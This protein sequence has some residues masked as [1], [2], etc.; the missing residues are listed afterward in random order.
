MPWTGFLLDESVI[1]SERFKAN[2][3]EPQQVFHQVN[4]AGR[5]VFLNIFLSDIIGSK[6][7]LN[8]LRIFTEIPMEVVSTNVVENGKKRRLSGKT[9]YTIGLAGKE[10]LMFDKAPPNEL[11][12]VAVEAKSDITDDG[13]WQ[14]VAETATIYKARKDAGKQKCSVWGVITNASSWRFIYIDEKGLLWRSQLFTIE[15]DAYDEEKVTIIYRML[16]YVVDRCLKACTPNTTLDS[17]S[18]H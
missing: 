7:F 17:F 18:G 10:L 16:H 4:E 13:F 14:C 3:I 6:P 11:H 12:L 9:D 15:L 8:K 2:F 5:R 1:P